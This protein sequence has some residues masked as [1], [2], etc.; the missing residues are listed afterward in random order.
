VI[1]V[2]EY[3]RKPHTKAQE[4]A[5]SA[6]LVQ[7][8]ALRLEAEKAGVVRATDP[9]T[10][11]EISGIKNG[12]GDGGFRSPE[13]KT[14]A[15][16]SAHRSGEAVDIYDPDNHLDNWITDEVLTRY[17]LYREDPLRTPGWCHLQSRSPG[18]GKRT[19]QP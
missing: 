11:C 10:D 13:S 18:S 2:V 14:G 4:E 6:L 15:S 17:G 5:A 8:E 19:F 1:Y 16:G 9:D 12:S 7:V 3:F